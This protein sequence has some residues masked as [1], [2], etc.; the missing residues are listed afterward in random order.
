MLVNILFPVYKPLLPKAFRLY[1]YLQEIDDNRYYTNYGPLIR[2]FESLL[3]QHFNV[4]PNR[5]VTAA[6]GTL[7]LTQMLKTVVTNKKKYCV[8]PSWTFVATP[9]AAVTA[10][11]IPYFVDVD[12]NTWSL[13]PEGL[14]SQLNKDEIAAIIVVAPFGAPLDLSQWEG[15][16]QETG[17]PV[18]I[19]AAASFDAFTQ[20]QTSLPFMVSLHATKVFGIGEGAVII[21]GTSEEAKNNRLWG[22]FGFDTNRQ[23][24]I[25]GINSKLSEYAAAMGLAAFEEWQEKRNSWQFIT[26]IFVRK[27]TEINDIKLP[28]FFDDK[29][30]SSYGIIELPTYAQTS[31]IAEHLKSK[32]IQTL[33][34]WD[35]GCHKQPAYL[36]YPKSNLSNTDYLANHTVGL[37]FWIGMDEQ[38]FSFIF[39]ELASALERCHKDNPDHT[40]L[41]Q[42]SL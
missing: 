22:T 2:Q 15:F 29:W 1:T 33:A 6:N 31:I 39:Q 13:L 24:L 34:W 19:D 17:I 10:G 16:C 14:P 21:A 27:V 9:A 32:R 36:N 35:E 8:M 41:L 4:D 40:P 38:D 23:S 18:I 11:L 20:V 30:V 28:P 25:P 37:P 7:A 5:V 3:A 26:D 42:S 12:I